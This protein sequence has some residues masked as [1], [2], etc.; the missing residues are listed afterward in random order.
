MIPSWLS[1]LTWR[2]LI[3]WVLVALPLSGYLTF[4]PGNKI[5]VPSFVWPPIG[6]IVKY[7]AGFAAVLVG[8]LGKLPS[9]SRTGDARN[10]WF[11]GALFVSVASLFIY[12]Y[13]LSVYVQGVHTPENGMQY[14]VIGSERT[15]QS[16]LCRPN[17]SDEDLLKCGGLEDGDIETLWTVS[18]VRKARLE[19]FMSYVVLLGAL[20]VAIT[21]ASPRST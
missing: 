8:L 6:S 2:N 14:R 5:H 7:A 20:N 3:R 21:A 9:R 15:S 12:A 16:T 10:R 13:F 19:L 4:A 11:N 17:K 18:S 1:K